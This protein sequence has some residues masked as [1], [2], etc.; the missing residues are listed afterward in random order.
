MEEE[1]ALA[2]LYN[3]QSVAEQR[4]I[5]VAFSELMEQNIHKDTSYNC[6]SKMFYLQRKTITC[7]FGGL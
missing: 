5:A 3:D 4:S 6:R 1:D 2:I 7:T